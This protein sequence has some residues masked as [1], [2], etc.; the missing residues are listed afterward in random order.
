[1]TL[2]FGLMV[3]NGCTDKNGNPVG[4][5]TFQRDQF[6]EELSLTLYA[7]QS[8]TFYFNELQSGLAP[9]LILG[10]R[11]GRE[12]QSI[13]RLQVSDIP[14][15]VVVDSAVVYLFVQQVLGDTLQMTP[16]DVWEVNG[17]W[18]EEEITSQS[19]VNEALQGGKL[20]IT[21]GIINSDTLSF[22]LPVEFAQKWVNDSLEADKGIMLSYPVSDDGNLL[23][24]YASD[25]GSANG[26]IHFYT[27]KDTLFTEKRCFFLNDAYV[28]QY[29]IVQNP[30]RL[31]IH[32]GIT[33]RSFLEFD[34]SAIPENAT[35]NYAELNLW[36]DTLQSWPD[37]TPEL[38]VQAMR[39]TS[40][41]T[42]NGESVPETTEEA[43]HSG[44][45]AA[46]TLAMAISTQVQ[47]WTSSFQENFGFVLAGGSENSFWGA[48]SF[49][50]A[51]A[52]SS[53]RPKIRV[54]YSIPPVSSTDD[55]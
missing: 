38:A 20:N 23:R 26:L 50:S 40:E 51:T 11:H 21:P 32:D 44:L 30:N 17:T 13:H 28:S 47:A 27:H 2:S 1:M 12:F 14:D 35:I 34:F 3:L 7:A 37:N 49:F 43:I 10:S 18:D 41:F 5:D 45:L 53:L 39:V 8:D 19:I 29:N 54:I 22:H 36:V 55:Q 52:D 24:I 6:G 4:L 33:Y 31:W 16:P 25:N 42:P 15:S 9:Y 48:R 46:D